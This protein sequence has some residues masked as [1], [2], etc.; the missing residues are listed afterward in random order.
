MIRT[1]ANVLGG[2]ITETVHERLC[3]SDMDH[4]GSGVASE[5]VPL[6]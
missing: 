4:D 2:T 3:R 6:T 5:L 1:V